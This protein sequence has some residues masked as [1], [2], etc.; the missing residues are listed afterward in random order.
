MRSRRGHFGT[1]NSSWIRLHT[2]V[3]QEIKILHK[4]SYRNSTLNIS[5]KIYFQSSLSSSTNEVLFD[6]SDITLNY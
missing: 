1:S 5:I 3:S 4:V 2:S 6:S